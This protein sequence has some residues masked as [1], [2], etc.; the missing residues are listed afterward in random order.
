MRRDCR[1]QVAQ[2]HENVCASSPS[3]DG[4]KTDLNACSISGEECKF[5]SCVDQTVG[6]FSDNRVEMLGR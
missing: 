1:T 3:R 4:C 2:V 5:L 6:N